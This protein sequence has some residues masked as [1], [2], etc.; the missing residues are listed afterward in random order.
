MSMATLQRPTT[1]GTR[2]GPSATTAEEQQWERKEEGLGPGATSWEE[3]R[4]TVSSIGH[5]GYGDSNE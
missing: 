5:H 1:T 4:E 3:E 2:T